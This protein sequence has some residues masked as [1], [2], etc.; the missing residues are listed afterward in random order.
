MLYML[1]YV[2]AVSMVIVGAILTFGHQKS[3]EK[4]YDSRSIPSGVS[5]N[6]INSI[7]YIMY[8]FMI[9]TPLLNTLYV[10]SIVYKIITDVVKKVSKG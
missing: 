4:V 2:Y 10:F 6:F 9:F 5:P 1:D 7:M 8:V 3:F